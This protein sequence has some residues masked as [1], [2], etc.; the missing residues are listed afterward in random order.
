[1]TCGTGP[2]ISFEFRN[3][4]RETYLKIRPR[5]MQFDRTRGKFDQCQ[6]EFS[7][8][9]A[10]HIRPYLNNEDS[11]LRQPLPV[12]LFIEGSP[13][14]RL[15]WVPDGVRFGEDNVH[16]EFHDPQKYLTRGV[17]DVRRKNIKLREAYEM[18]FEKRDT[19]GPALFND[20]KFTV[21]EEAFNELRTERSNLSEVNFD[22]ENTSDLIAEE[23]RE[24]PALSMIQKS[25][26]IK[27]LEQENVYN[28]IEGNY[29]IDFDKISPWECITRLN[30]KFGVRTWAH[31]DGN[32]Y[33]GS[34][35]STGVPH[36]SAQDDSRVWKIDNYNVNSP[37][38]PVA[39][40]VI[41][42]GW[43]ADPSEDWV[44]QATEIANLNRGT[45]DFRI[46]AVASVDSGYLPGQEIFEEHIDAKKDSLEEI[47]TRKMM[48]K[49]KEQ[50]S[51]YIE[52]IPEFSG[53]EAS[54]IRFVQIGD[55]VITIPP[56]DGK[57]CDTNIQKEIFDV[58][59]VQMELQESGSWNV[60]V[61][62]VK[63]LDDELH[64]KNIDTR[65]RYYDPFNK[66][67]I[68]EEQYTYMQSEDNKDFWP[69]FI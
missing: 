21:P 18:V 55:V 9:V 34:R 29:A 14:Y 59:G 38:D 63:Q 6:A 57:D 28:I 10:D 27:S 65:L 19:S 42:G 58:V 1:M 26:V 52:F 66:E 41:R 11:F 25:S 49:Q 24:E 68:E 62:V 12:T 33:V 53:T 44:D 60:R 30:E 16:I 43:A 4:D 8:E 23:A 40:S 5:S 32:L 54:D 45:K 47:A 2:N 46:E 39:K 17:V 67:T 7:Q 31:P 13:I 69:D 50:N 48:N 20:I 37:R 56:N 3:E 36:L 22:E 64:P 15:L 35:K 61:D 51:G